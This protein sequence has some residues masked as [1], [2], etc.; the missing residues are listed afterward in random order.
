MIALQR[1]DLEAVSA[2]G[3]FDR[4]AGGSFNLGID[5]VFGERADQAF[6]LWRVAAATLS[7]AAGVRH[8]AITGG[9]TQILHLGCGMPTAPAWEHTMFPGGIRELAVDA[10]PVV[11]GIRHRQAQRERLRGSTPACIDIRD[12]CTVLD[13]ARQVL[14]LTQPILLQATG[15]LDHLLDDDRPGEVLAA[16][17]GALAP[18][19]HLALSHLTPY[20]DPDGSDGHAALTSLLRAYQDA[21]IPLTA[22][23]PEVVDSWLGPLEARGRHRAAPYL[24]LASGRITDTGRDTPASRARRRQRRP[25]PRPRP[26]PQ[27]TTRTDDA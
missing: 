4:A 14:D 6:P 16:Y 27:G 10:D 8:D 5:R 2:A 15:V 22:R 18:G 17:R 13:T 11:I 21:G 12:I 3:V 1:S 26:R 9:V 23:A 24:H 19:S 25:R 20:D 7:F